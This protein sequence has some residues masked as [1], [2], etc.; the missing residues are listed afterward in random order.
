MLN[1]LEQRR[2]KPAPGKPE[3]DWLQSERAAPLAKSNKKFPYA[4][5]LLFLIVIAMAAVSWKFDLLALISGE[6]SQLAAKAVPAHD[7]AATPNSA[8]IPVDKSTLDPNFASLRKVTKLAGGKPGLRFELD[9]RVEFQSRQLEQRVMLRMSDTRNRLGV[10][11]LEFADPLGPLLIKENDNGL[12]FE[13]LVDK[14]LL[15]SVGQSTSI[16]G[17]SIVEIRF[18]RPAISDNESIDN[19]AVAVEVY[20]ER[21]VTK[22]QVPNTVAK[23]IVTALKGNKLER[24]DVDIAQSKPPPKTE[25]IKQFVPLSN[26]QR[27]NKTHSEAKQLLR[28]GDNLRAEKLL[29]DFIT[30]QPLARRSGEMLAS[31]YLSQQRFDK[32]RSLIGVLRDTYPTDAGLLS[33][34]ARLL[35]LGGQADK[36]VS[37]LMAYKPDIASHEDYYELLGLAARKNEQYLLSEQVYKGL[38]DVNAGRGDRWVGLAIALDAQG[39]SAAARS[40]FREALK[41]GTTSTKLADYARRRLNTVAR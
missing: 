15:S 3:L 40:A 22:T 11:R 10:S 32:A 33:I 4:Y 24:S 28:V 21:P 34:E 41:T 17:G 14:G 18:E 16:G 25:D 6:G 31:I 36:A 8:E 27:D 35:L 7:S 26:K 1:D 37:L 12:S 29:E 9:Q 30:Q 13:L 20:A 23:P 19:K 2:G 5:L 38:L 39:K